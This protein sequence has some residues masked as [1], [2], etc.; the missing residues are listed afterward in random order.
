MLDAIESLASGFAL[1][2]PDERLVICNSKFRFA[3]SLI[4]NHIRRGAK[5]ED[6]TR[7]YAEA[8][9]NLHGNAA[10]ID[11]FVSKCM[12][13]YRNATGNLVYLAPDGLWYRMMDYR[14]QDGGGMVIHTGITESKNHEMQLLAAKDQADSAN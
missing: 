4:E 8:N 14:S 12:Q 7:R 2:D 13:H 5:L 6:M 10:A 3:F 11:G 1:F 9:E